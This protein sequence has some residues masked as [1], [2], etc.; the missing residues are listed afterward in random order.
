[1]APSASNT[2]A[3]FNNGNGGATSPL[4]ITQLGALRSLRNTLDDSAG[5]SVSLGCVSGQGG[6][7]TNLS[8]AACQIGVYAG[9][10]GNAPA[11]TTMGY[12]QALGTA[13]AVIPLQLNPYSGVVYTRNNILDDNNGNIS[14][15]SSN[16]N[17]ASNTPMTVMCPILSTGA[18]TYIQVGKALGAYA[19]AALGFTSNAVGNLSTASLSINGGPAL[20]INGAGAVNTP[21]VSVDDGNGSLTGVQ[22]CFTGTVNSAVPNG[23]ASVVVGTTGGT[24]PFIQAHYNNNS[25]TQLTLNPSGGKV[26]TPLVTLD[27]GGGVFSAPQVKA[28]GLQVLGNAIFNASGI[29][30]TLP[31][32]TG[33]F[34]LTSQIPSV[35][36]FFL[37]RWVTNSTPSVVLYNQSSSGITSATS[38]GNAYT[39]TITL[40]AGNYNMTCNVTFLGSSAANITITTDSNTTM[41]PS[42]TATSNSYNLFNGT[43]ASYPY[44]VPAG[45]FTLSTSASST[46]TFNFS[47]VINLV[48]SVF[49]QAL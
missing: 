33:T 13:S 24:A 5:N 49:I 28:T 37:G 44:N 39:T 48:G 40:P 9:G 25:Y 31:S 27:D 23:T 6:I 8:Q 12:V 4:T 22:G 34:A 32:T 46:I 10:Q 20:S 19:C 2:L 18:S 11:S 26:A 15:V 47:A 17:G 42:S 30:C 43:V 36:S 16:N 38:V 3:V 41:Y 35:K 1:M 21:H 14:I 7:V 29:G 45:S